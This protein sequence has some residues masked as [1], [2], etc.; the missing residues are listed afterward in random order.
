M[1]QTV[2]ETYSLRPTVMLASL[3]PKLREQFAEF[4]VDISLAILGS[5][6]ANPPVSV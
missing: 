2:A 5:F 3:L 1:Y 6:T 4:L